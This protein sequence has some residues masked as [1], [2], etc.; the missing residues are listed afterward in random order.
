M[1]K[2]T[3]HYF[4][5][6]HHGPGSSKRLLAALETLQPAKVLI[7]G[8]QDCSEL[9]PLLAHQQMRPPVSL[10]AYNKDTPEQSL[11]FPFADYSPEYQACCWA[12][13]QQAD[14]A[15]I[16][17]PVSVRLAEMAQ[18]AVRLEAEDASDP[19]DESTTPSDPD[20]STEPSNQAAASEIQKDT[21]NESE[22]ITGIES[23]ANS[24]EA[25]AKAI[26]N[27]LDTIHHDPIGTL[28][29]LAGYEDGESWWNDWFEQNYSEDTELFDA[30]ESAMTA[31]REQ[32][33]E[34]VN[35]ESEISTTDN[36]ERQTSRYQWELMREAFMRLE[37]IKAAK[38]VEGPVAVICGAWHVPALK[39]KHTQKDDRALLKSLPTKLPKSRVKATWI[40][41]TS[42]RLATYSGYGAGVDA[43]MWY[44]HLWEQRDNPDAMSHWLTQ[45][46]QTLREAGQ[47][48]STASVI[49]AVRL[50]HSL[51]SLRERPTPGFEEMREASIACLCFG[52]TQLWHQLEQQILLGNA[53]GRIPDN[54]PL[55]P[56]LE[57]LQRLQKQARLKPEALAREV[58]V[59]L[60]SQTGLLKSSLLHR[61]NALNVP[62]GQCHDTSGRGTF[63]ENWT[64]KW[65][66]EFAVQL[67]ENL[68]YGSTIA[69][70]ANNRMSE[71]L[72]QEQNLG[73]LAGLVQQCMDARLEAATKQGL[74]RIEERSA[75][76]DN[77]L[78]L[79]L[80]LPPLVNISRYGTARKVSQAHID[81]LIERLA[82]QAALSLPYACRSLNDEEAQ[83]LHTC[84]DQA[85]RTV[86][87]AELD[88]GITEIW[89]QALTETLEFSNTHQLLAGLCARLLY[90]GE[91]YDAG[92][93]QTTL[94][95]MLSPAIPAVEAAHFFD[96][97]FSS[98]TQHLLYD[99]LL[100]NAVEHWLLSLDEENFVEHL[101][102]FRRVFAD[103]DSMERKRLLDAVLNKR[104]QQHTEYVFNETQGA[105]W[106]TQQQRLLLLMQRN[107]SWLQT[108]SS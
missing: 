51:S 28:A 103:L 58:S 61:L 56:L 33:A 74:Q 98:A 25:S 70:A 38:G 29:K 69:Q 81:Q 27:V 31:L 17:L 101:P 46:T 108:Q 3:I 54:A 63:R 55:A 42:P 32:E 67:V 79:L 21:A 91:I 87:L 94:E 84:L 96:G 92:Q 5:I 34:R 8:P 78:E 77:C 44:Q 24:T 95:R 85:H 48:I 76:T 71:R 93:I 16:D 73:K 88:Q 47:V 26:N 19:T 6:R 45:V 83:H 2:A 105:A 36:A 30:I 50:G 20:T 100:R 43:P 66:P 18:Q 99:S 64:L 72:E 11:Y 12:V 60:R 9:L 49:E 59:D 41:W 10:L 40:P 107:K 90:Q 22:E 106:D 89:W 104:Q 23:D 13:T 53:V 37:I 35:A 75:H 65:E 80:S 86:L 15:F 57:D 62:W 52:E 14:V 68:V 7:E 4:G 82:T 102:L 1:A 97:F 39:A